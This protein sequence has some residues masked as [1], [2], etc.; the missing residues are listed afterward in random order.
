LSKFASS[1][2]LARAAASDFLMKEAPFNMKLTYGE[3]NRGKDD[4]NARDEEIVVQGVID[5]IFEEEDG[6]VIVDYK[7]GWFDVADYENEAGRVR[8]V[9]GEQLRLYRRAAELIF[10]KPVKE[11]VVY[12]TGAGVT[13]DIP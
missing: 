4:E 10:E 6:L 11:S 12:M 7:T 9:Y 5:C 3:T 13:I 2:I 8:S 1:D